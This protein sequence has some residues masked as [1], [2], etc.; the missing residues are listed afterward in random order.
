MIPVRHMANLTK[1]NRRLARFYQLIFGMDELWNEWQNSAAAFYITD[2]YL[3]YNCLEILPVMSRPASVRIDHIGFQIDKESCEKKLAALDK[4]IKLEQSP[5]DGR[6]E[7]WRF[8]DPE[9]NLV[10]IAR[11][12]WGTG[13]STNVPL[14]RHTT[15]HA[16]DHERLA[17]FYKFVFDMKQVRRQRIAATDTNA[18]HLSDGN[19]SLSLVKNSPI[20]TRGFQVIG[21]HVRSIAEIEE[22]LKTSPPFLYPQEP[23][24]EILHRTAD[25]PFKEHYLR[26]PDGNIVDL[27]E[28][29]WEV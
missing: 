11:L 14:L 20:E 6:Y 7:D 9:G 15:I 4:P 24:V 18:I 28:E 1:N 25:S 23:K 12:G 13:D 29:G 3:N 21:F 22:R 10:E 5:Q 19:F 16:R 27:S 8:E 17:D 2:G 26:D